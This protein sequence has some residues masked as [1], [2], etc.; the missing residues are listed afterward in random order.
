MSARDRL[1]PTRFPHVPSIDKNHLARYLQILSANLSSSSSSPR[2]Y[3]LALGFAALLALMLVITVIAVS[4]MDTGQQRLDEV[5]R[6]EMAKASLASEMRFYVEQRRNAIDQMMLLSDPF[7]RHQQLL[8]FNDMA[9]NFRGARERLVAMPLE[10]DE[11][12]LL[13][14][15]NEL[16]AVA[17]PLQLQVVTLIATDRI[18]DAKAFLFRTAKPAQDRAM[19]SLMTLQT[20]QEKHAALR[21]SA[22]AGEYRHSRATMLALSAIV[23]LFGAGIAIGVLRRKAKGDLALH[24]EKERAL[25][26]ID[27]IGDAVIRLNTAGGIEYLNPCASRMTGWSS[28]EATGRLARDIVHLAQDQDARVHTDVAQEVLVTGQPCVDIGEHTLIGRGGERHLVEGSVVPIQDDGERV[29][30]AVV[31]LRDITEMRALSLELAYY[32]THDALTGLINRREFEN[33]LKAAIETTRVDG[34]RHVLAYLDLDLFKTVNDICGHLAG[35]ELLRQIGNLLR[36]SVGSD[37]SVARIGGDEFGLLLLNRS[38]DEGTHVC[39]GIRHLIRDYRFTWENKTFDI[40]ASI[41]VVGIGPSVGTLHDI[42]QTADGACQYAKAQGRNRVNV[43][44][45][46]PRWGERSDIGWA[47]ALSTA[48]AKDQFVL[49]GQWV[50]PLGG[51][52]P[53]SHC[54]ILARL[55][56]PDGQCISPGAFLPA[57]ERYHM[58]PAIDRWVV[59]ETLSTL[60]THGLSVDDPTLFNINLSGQSLC[61]PDF[62][63]FVLHRFEESGLAPGRICFEITET[64]AISN[65]T[66]A[67][68]FMSRL[69]DIGCTFALD[70]F[71][72]GLSS[73]GYLKKMPVSFLKIDGVFVRDVSDDPVDRSMVQCINEMARVMGIETIAEYVENEA[74]ERELRAMGVGYGQGFLMARPRPLCEMLHEAAFAD[75]ASAGLAHASN[76][77]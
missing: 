36:D 35:D 48:L 23:L 8:V 25:V 62:L 64:A 72:S 12:Q 58:M 46:I 24:A 50:Y 77:A 73:F 74:I 6:Q 37:G 54:E 30:G 52:S 59:R 22:A 53:P 10:D 69:S 14:R 49:Y 27:A 75:S 3:G 9:S 42:L 68:R 56:R 31:V 13:N 61:D 47:E 63:D 2:E 65:M 45:H 7:D 44:N 34:S 66:S 29:M 76:P 32:A 43:A 55:R 67:S 11:R 15:L 19:Q 41:G 40:G 60:G 26:T 5:V 51:E 17:A 39:D 70:D 57:A 38:V 33:R 28:A 1:T 16:V 71:G 20:M 21:V 4:H 18:T